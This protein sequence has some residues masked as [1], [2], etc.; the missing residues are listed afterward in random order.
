MREGGREN[1]RERRVEKESKC[2]R[3]L[4][5]LLK[6]K[7]IIIISFKFQWLNR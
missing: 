2:V 4:T 5:N 7:P 6:Q 3:E 1:E